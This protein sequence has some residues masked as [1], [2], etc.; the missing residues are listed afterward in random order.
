MNELIFTFAYP[1]HWQ[2]AHDGVIFDDFSEVVQR[3]FPEEV[4]ENI[5]F[6]SEPEGAILSLQRQGHCKLCPRENDIDH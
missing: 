5:R 3:C 1:V 2:T 4:Q 6:V